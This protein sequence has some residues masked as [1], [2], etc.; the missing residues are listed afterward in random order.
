MVSESSV[1]VALK[2]VKDPELGRDLVSLGMIRD[3]SVDGGNVSLSIVL[4]TPACPMKSQ[5]KAAAEQAVMAIP[6]VQEVDIK[7]DAKVNAAPGSKIEQIIPGVKNIIAVASGKGGVGKS[8]VSVNLALG[9]AEAGANVGLMD[10]DIYGPSLPRLMGINEPPLSKDGKIVP[11]EMH[12]IK[13]MSIGFMLPEEAAV[14][15]RGPMVSGAIRQM[16][17]EVA[18]GELDYLVVDLPPGTG[19][20]QLTLAQT[21]PLTGVVVVTTSQDMALSIATKAAQMFRK[22]DVPVL[23]IVENMSYFL[24]PHCG[25]RTDIFSH[26]GATAAADRLEIP[27]LGQVPLEPETVIDSDRG[28]PTITARPASAQAEAFRQIAHRVAGRVSV[29]SCFEPPLQ[30]T[31]ES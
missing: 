21:V 24:C 27:V 29:V 25:G 18:W 4:T 20:A 31:A 30:L 28:V 10:A 26:G 19:D 17:A 9:L 6:G 23:G 2:R 14:I 5:I 1:I 22:M 3:V 11:I 12:G 8:T 15:W 13:L 16:L 7:L